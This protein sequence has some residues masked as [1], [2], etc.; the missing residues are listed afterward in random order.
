[1]LRSGDGRPGIVRHHVHRRPAGSRQRRQSGEE[2]D[3]AALRL[4]GIEVVDRLQAQREP[5]RAHRRRQLQD[6]RR[7]GHPADA[8]GPAR[9]AGEEP[10]AVRHRADRRRPGQAHRDAAAGHPDRRRARH[11]QVPEGPE[12]EEGPGGDSGRP[13]ARVVAV[14]GRAADRDPAAARRRTS[15]SSCSSATTASDRAPADSTSPIVGAGAAGLATA[16]FTRA[17]TRARASSCST[18]RAQ[19]GAKILVSGGSRC[20]VTN[21]GRHRGGLQRRA[22]GDHPPRAARVS[23]RRTTVAFFREIGVPLHEEPGGKLFP[24]TQSVAR[25]RSRRCCARSARAASSCAPATAC[26]TSRATATLFRVATARGDRSARGAIVLATGGLSL[27]KTGSDGWGYERRARAS[28]TRSC[29]RRR[30]SR[31]WCSRTPAG[32]AMHRA[33][34]RRRAARAARPARGRRGRRAHRRARCCGRTS[35]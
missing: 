24:D 3:R 32:D 11:R 4:Q 2:R 9:R 23:G 10:Q 5:H 18:A 31:R 7:V 12:A 30:R 8:D 22:P 6:G 19:P 17:P 26:S 28:A 33:L 20:N 25:R 1:M 35:A 27:P 14:E 21:I 29:R 34:S 16:I 15:A 13:A